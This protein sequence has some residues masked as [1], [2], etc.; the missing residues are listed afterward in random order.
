MTSGVSLTPHQSDVLFDAACLMLKRG[1]ERQN[2]KDPAVEGEVR[3][4]FEEQALGGICGIE[5]H[6]TVETDMGTG[7]VKYLVRP[8]D[9]KRRELEWTSFSSFEEL[10][11]EL[12]AHPSRY[13]PA[14]N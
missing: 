10:E 14:Y 2:I 12:N 4:K 1:R 11:A 13:A 6:A 3:T 9:A 5:F 8:F 7:N